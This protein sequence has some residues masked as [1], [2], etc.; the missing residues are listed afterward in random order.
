MKLYKS[1]LLVV[2]TL[3]FA[4][5][6]LEEEPPYLS[7]ANVYSS[8]ET[9]AAAVDG[10]YRGL[11]EYQYYGNQFMVLTYLNSGFGVTRRGG[12]R[13]NNADNSTLSSLKS[14]S[15]TL[16][17]TNSWRGIYRVIARANDAIASVNP[18]DNPASQD[19]LIINDATG[20]AYFLRAFNYFN[21]VRMWG[22]V[23]LR[24]DPASKETIN[25]AKS[26]ISEIYAQIIE[27]AKLAQKYMNGAIGNGT[28]K[29]YAA[30]MLLA[31]VYMT[32]ATAP[33]S[34][35][36]ESANYW[37][38][39]YDEAIKAYG[40]YS[41]VANYGDLFVENN[42][43]L[44]ESIFEL[45]SSLTATLDHTRAF[46]PN[47]Y[48]KAN[49]FGWLI[50]NV[51]VYNRHR[52]AYP[53]DPRIDITYVSTWTRQN[54]GSTQNSYPVNPNRGWFGVAFP[55]IYKLGS[56]DITNEA[57]ETTK[58]F[59]VYRYADLL[60][61]LAEISNELQ[62]GEQLGY[63]TEVLDRAGLTPRAEYSAGQDSFRDAI[64]REYEFELAAEG[65]DS[66]NNRRRGY[67]YFLNQVILPHNNGPL[68][69]ENVDVTLET[70]E[71]RVMFLP[72]SQTEIDRNELITE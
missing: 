22:E 47:W 44:S 43:N 14:T 45:K 29:Q 1:Y 27:D 19:E 65:H 15:N 11:I 49:T 5:C 20:H 53:G 12:Q 58:N 17:L 6:S 35:Q 33:A 71:D 25:L 48:T 68:F 28:P 10:M 13:N 40:Q 62:N 16:Q 46:T 55:Y 23:P 67:D 41:L 2:I 38:L 51:A 57:R 32:L 50:A 60:L 61:M 30:D 37:Q 3:I 39:A 69:K 36:P 72:I 56:Q 26:S 4:S 64:M 18:T 34:Y 42:N 7:N 70:A 8:S 21:L 66:F 24:T 63:V 31:K 59:M 54:N 9:S 52:D